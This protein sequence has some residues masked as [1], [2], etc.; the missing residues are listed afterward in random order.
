M[1]CQSLFSGENKKKIFQI[2]SCSNV[3]PSML[4]INT[5]YFVTNTGKPTGFKVL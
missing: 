3:L 4:N 5:I 1:R 2:V